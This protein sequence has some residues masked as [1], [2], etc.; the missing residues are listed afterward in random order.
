M[1]CGRG[2]QRVGLWY[3]SYAAPCLDKEHTHHERIV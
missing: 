2:A 1:G 3:L